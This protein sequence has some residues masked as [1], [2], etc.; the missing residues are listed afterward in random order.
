[1]SFL[2]DTIQAYMTYLPPLT[3]QPDFDAFW[4]ETLARTRALPLEPELTAVDYPSPYVSVYDI[5][6]NGFDRTRI[7]GWLLLP[8]FISR[9]QFPCLIQYHGFSGSRGEPW[10]LLPWVMQGLAVLAVDC[11]D[12]GGDSGNS[13]C[14]SN[15]LVANVTT[16]GILDPHEYYYRAVYMDCV[17]ALDFAV[18]CGQL[19]P[20]RLILHGRSQG[21]ALTMAVSA[22]DDRP[23][24][25][26]ADVP[27]NSNLEKRVEG[28]HGSFAAVTEYLRRYPERLTQVYTTLSYFDTMNLAGWINCPVYASVALGDQIC[29]AKLYFATYNR[30]DSPKEIT[31]YPFN[32][33][34]GADSRQMTRKLSY[35]QQSGLLAY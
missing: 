22:L 27:S 34:D 1:M 6:Y 5:S 25:A 10:E 18:S 32:G 24:L 8:R 11:R 35:L 14:Y 17:K 26:L 21:G 23:C 13:A 28:Q 3:R 7:R 16:R 12:Q 19:D 2:E 4:D 30:I 15:G 9:Q 20:D 29:P 31:V 33:H